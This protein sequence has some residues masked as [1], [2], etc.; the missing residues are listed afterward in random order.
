MTLVSCFNNTFS[1]NTSRVAVDFYGKRIPFSELDKNSNKVANALIRLGI[2]KGDKVA[3]FLDNSPELIYFFIG[4]LK[5]GC[6]VVPINT[7][8]KEAEVGHMLSNSGSKLI[9][10]NTERMKVL[11]N[12]KGNLEELRHIITVENNEKYTS[13]DN[14]VKNSMENEP[15]IK[16]S[17]DDGAI[18]FYT[19]GTT[20]K[21]KGALLTHY[22]VESNLK[23]LKEAWHWTDNDKLL[24]CLPLYHIHGLGVALCGSFYN[25]SFIVL[26][27][28]FLPDDV[29]P[30]IQQHE[31]TLFMRVPT[32][33]IKILEAKDREKYDI[34]S[35][36]LFISGSAPLSSETFKEFKDVFGHEILERAGMSETM[37]NFS[38][39]YKGKKK[40]GTVGKPL[41]GVEV[42]IVDADFNDVEK[43]E[44]GEIMIKGPNILKEYWN[45]PRLNGEA[46][47]QGWFRTGDIGRMDEDGYIIFVGRARDMIITGGLKVYPREVEETIDQHPAVKESAVVGVP[48]KLFGESVRAYVVL[49][50]N[51][52]AREEEIISFCRQKLAGFKKPKNVEFL[53]ELPRT[54]TGKVQKNILRERAMKSKAS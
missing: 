26:R 22:N 20:G 13:F 14:F 41:P 34:S 4:A 42:R 10:V 37:M 54:S 24:L 45:F 25:G 8:Y 21:S 29:L 5:A 32:M 43:G 9:L 52:N 15:N 27:K 28:K 40:P 50:E 30:L 53:K 36:R 47:R 6:V 33:Y 39:P 11:E 16:L 51:A 49:K 2:K 19:S 35:M 38:N 3:Q 18:I 46:F 23:A 44:A 1:K 12:C 31:C 48:D 7:Y 17:N